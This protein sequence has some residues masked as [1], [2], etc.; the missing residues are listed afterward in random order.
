MINEYKNEFNSFYFAC[1][2]LALS[3]GSTYIFTFVIIVIEQFC[4]WLFFSM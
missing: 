3:V 1:N 2:F 4:I